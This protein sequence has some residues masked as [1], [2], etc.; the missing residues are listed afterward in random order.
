M[1][2]ISFIRNLFKKGKN[3]SQEPLT[4]EYLIVFQKS[5]LPI[6][7]KCFGDFCG[8][9]MVDDT[10]L[11]G[12]LSAMTSMPTFF[13]KDE[14]L[15]A[16]EMGFTK[17]IFSHTLPSGH[18]ICLGFNKNTITDSNQSRIDELFQQINKFVEKDK[19]DVD[20]SLL[21]SEEISPIVDE[22][23]DQ[24]V[25]PWIHVSA[26]YTKHHSEG[27]PIC[28]DGP[29]YRGE[30]DEGIKEPVWKRL[31]DLYALGRKLFKDDIPKKR[32]KLKNRGLIE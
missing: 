20:W 15:N 32:E 7:S 29:L 5:G 31:K 4:L 9:L 30:N 17:L 2:K 1:N 3:A 16:I 28:I 18:V 13:A 12:F 23:L 21:S 22:L 19:Q 25:N 26:K 27:C 11:S 14:K 10:L 24:I 6:F 8:V